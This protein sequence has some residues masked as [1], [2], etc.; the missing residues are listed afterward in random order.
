MST[1]G[2]LVAMSGGVDS[3]VAAYLLRQQGYR[4]EG[5]TMR[6]YQ[7]PP[8]REAGEE[9]AA[10]TPAGTPGGHTCCSLKDVRDA[11]L[12]AA[13]IGIPYASVDYSVDFRRHVIDKFIRVY[14]EGG[15]PNPCIDCNRYLKFGAL[16]DLAMQKGLDYIATGHYARVR[17]D[18]ERSR[19]LLM[20]AADERK[21][22]SYVLY[23]LEQEQL[24]HILFPLGE[25]SKDETRQLAELLQLGN[26]HKADSQDICFVP[27]GDYV[28]FMEEYTGRRYPEGDFLDETGRVIGR[29][30]GAVRYT[31][32]QRKGLGLS[33][34]APVYVCGKDMQRNT[35]TV[36]SEDHVMARELTA[37]DVNW[38]SIDDLTAPMKVTARTRYHQKEASGTVRPAEDGR[39]RFTFDE[40]VRAATP[41]QALVLYDGDLVVGG[42]TIESVR[43]M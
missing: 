34:G 43:T 24:A 7:Q 36:G 2:V 11:S 4:C 15:T 32:G 38:I 22:Q 25:M 17:W 13:R 19:Y 28:R 6:L 8:T 29:H 37:R 23:R 20:K 30:K 39:I 26:A 40:P 33:M 35:V 5:I 3:S 14:E 1:Q 42:G 12:V 31:I 16:L 9:N 10:G 27:D 18:E 41:G 21:D